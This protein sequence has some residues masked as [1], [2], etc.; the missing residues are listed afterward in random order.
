[1]ISAIIVICIAV[2]A[3]AG[4]AIVALGDGRSRNVKL[5]L[6]ALQREAVLPDCPDEAADIRSEEHIS[7]IGWLNRW[8]VRVNIAPRT[9]LLLYQADVK[10]PAETLLLTS[11]GGW[12]TIGALL[13]FRTGSLIASVSIAAA[14]IPAP[15]MYI[16]RARARRFAK[17]EQQFPEALDILVSALKVGH[18]LITGIGALGQDS[19]EP[20]ARE[21]RKMFDEQNF[22]LDLRTAMLN[23]TV[24]VPLQDVRIFVAAALIQKESGGNL[25]E[26]LDKVAQT[27]R[28]RFRLKKQIKVHTAQGRL[29]GWILSL[30]PVVLG[31]GMY[32]GNPE[33]MSVLWTR[34]LGLKLLYTAVCMIIV[35]CLIIRKIVRIRV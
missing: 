23:L 20:L 10:A 13:Y 2:F 8:M 33:S 32:L 4:L 17:F 12:V 9:R 15:L 31:F 28:E 26:V 24:R 3:I 21:F 35:G 5:R 25:A 22:G 16:L 7:G 18:S 27:I 1:V 30:L 6:E 19:A 14:F 29:T 11:L 34:P